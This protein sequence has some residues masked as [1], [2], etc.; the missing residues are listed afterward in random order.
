MRSKTQPFLS[1][2]FANVLPDMDFIVLAV[3]ANEVCASSCL[4]NNLYDFVISPKFRFD[5]D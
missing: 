2:A 3:R 4:N 1:N 5:F